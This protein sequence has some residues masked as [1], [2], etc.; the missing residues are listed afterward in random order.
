M[1]FLIK[2]IYLFFLTLCLA[3]ILED[4][5]LISTIFIN[6]PTNFQKECTNM[7]DHFEN[8]HSICFEDE[9]FFNDFTVKINNQFCY[10]VLIPFYTINFKSS[11]YTS[12]W[13]PPKAI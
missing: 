1:N 6:N 13:Q 11:F 5:G 8:L 3:L 9:I 2:Y 7:A 4:C 10:I 12:I